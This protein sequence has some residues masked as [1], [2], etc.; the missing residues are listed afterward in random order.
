MMDLLAYADGQHDLVAIAERIGADT[1]ECAAVAQ[2]LCA[3]GVL[4]RLE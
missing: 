2:R 1:L 3:A 4:K